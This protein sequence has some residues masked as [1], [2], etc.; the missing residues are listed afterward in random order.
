MFRLAKWENARRN[1]N[2]N[3]WQIKYLVFLSLPFYQ[4]KEAKFLNKLFILTRC[5]DFRIN[6]SCQNKLQKYWL[7]DSCNRMK[8]NIFQ[9]LFTITKSIYLILKVSN[10]VGF[11]QN[12]AWVSVFLLNSLLG[13]PVPA[14]GLCR[15][16]YDLVCP[17]SCVGS[18]NYLPRQVPRGSGIFTNNFTEKTLFS[19]FGKTG[20]SP[21]IGL[22]V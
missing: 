11:V 6:K 8:L 3:L 5:Q 2:Y 12:L 15:G 17:R 4:T 13:S 7:I 18:E 22:H 19:M 21:S 10:H 16:F 1:G 9:T 14:L 20:W